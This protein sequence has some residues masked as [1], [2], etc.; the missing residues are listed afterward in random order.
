MHNDDYVYL[1]PARE[2]MREIRLRHHH[3]L[4]TQNFVGKGYDA[5]FVANMQRVVAE[6][7]SPEGLVIHLAAVCDD[8]CSFCPNRVENRC[9]DEVSVF[10]KDRSAALFLDLAED[11]TWPAAPL[12]HLVR[13]RLKRL[14]DFDHLCGKCE[15]VG[16]CNERLAFIQRE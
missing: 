3:L 7:A 11:S 9:K 4:C 14:D 13:E 6:L 1:Y 5:L 12:V 8:I 15:W 2:Y 16:V 10:E